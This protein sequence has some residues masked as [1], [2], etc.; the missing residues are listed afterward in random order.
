[1]SAAPK[2]PAPPPVLGD[3]RYTLIRP[4]GEG[5]MAS[6]W[7]ARDAQVDGE[8]AVK[9]LHTDVAERKSYRSRFLAEARTMARMSHPSILRVFD[10]GEDESRPWFTM[11]VVD[12]GALIDMLEKNGKVEPLRALDIMFQTLQGLAAAHMAGVVHRD[13][14]PDNILISVDG[15]VRLS[16]FGIARI[17]NERVDHRTRTGVSMGTV[18]YMAPEQRE[19]ARGVGPGAD[20]Y[21]MGAT[22]YATVTGCEPP[23][24][25]AAHIDPKLLDNVP[26]AIRD[27][28]KNS[29]TYKAD[30]RYASARA[31]AVE[32]VEAYDAIARGRGL[33]EVSAEWMARFDRLLLEA[34]AYKP[35]FEPKKAAS[36]YDLP[37][38]K[39]EDTE[40]TTNEKARFIPA[41]S[42]DLESNAHTGVTPHKTPIVPQVRAEVPPA[43]KP[44]EMPW[45]LVIAIGIVVGFGLAVLGWAFGV[46]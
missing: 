31:M 1:M 29:T 39:G 20:I 45:T 21:A 7:L 3:G 18:G 27:V 23:D 14:K 2:R 40:E 35:T 17:R 8:V 12:G 36:E 42:L 9:I 11:D 41:M 30:T 38:E 34:A 24:L 13:I 4:L 33:P 44:F 19:N 32:L 22:L 6:V 46:G 16:D 28:V 10:L 5:G 43:A 37:A 25:F 26:P 15:D